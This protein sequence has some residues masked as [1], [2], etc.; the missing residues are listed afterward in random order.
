MRANYKQRLEIEKHCD[1]LLRL[2]GKSH[3]SAWAPLDIHEVVSKIKK[4]ISDIGYN[5]CFDE[6]GLRSLLLPTSALQEIAIDN[7]WGHD[8]NLIARRLE[9]EI[10]PEQNAQPGAPPDAFGSREL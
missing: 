10:N 2:L 5:G 3:P 7:G 6:E 4:C 9:A 8:F 1:D